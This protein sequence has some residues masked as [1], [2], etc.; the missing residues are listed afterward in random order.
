MLTCA[1][2]L[3]NKNKKNK[4]KYQYHAN[5]NTSPH[6]ESPLSANQIKLLLVMAGIEPN[7]GPSK[8]VA[9]RKSLYCN[10]CRKAG[11][12]TRNCYSK[13]LSREQAKLAEFKRQVKYIESELTNFEQSRKVN[14]WKPNSA[15]VAMIRSCRRQERWC[16][17]CFS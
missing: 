6:I 7:P 1:L 15:V 11:H 12:S 14:F 10:H 16:P 5:H 8:R 3:K 4:N 9:R 13:I 2:T 17:L